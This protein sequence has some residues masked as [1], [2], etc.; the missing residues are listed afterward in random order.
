M[1]L[2]I[3]DIRGRTIVAADGIVI[4][5]LTAVSVDTDTWRIDSIEAKLRKEVADLLGA[6]R[7]LFQA[8][9][10]KVPINQVQSVGDAVLLSVAGDEL[11]DAV[12]R[13][14]HDE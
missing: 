7:G 14:V 5:E 11:R 1:I 3:D 6:H 13:R 2:S 8:G 4:G 12:V 10:V 9:M